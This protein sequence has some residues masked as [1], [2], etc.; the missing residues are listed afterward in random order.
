MNTLQAHES[1]SVHVQS[2]CVDALTKSYT[3]LAIFLRVQLEHVTLISPNCMRMSFEPVYHLGGLLA[4]FVAKSREWSR[5][6][7]RA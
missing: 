4:S 7:C 5:G 2:I 3:P 6:V 1:T